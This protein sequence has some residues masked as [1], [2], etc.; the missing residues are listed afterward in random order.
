MRG[1]RGGET[2]L[3][4]ATTIVDTAFNRPKKDI[5]REPEFQERELD[6]NRESLERM[7]RTLDRDVDRALLRYRLLEVARLGASERIEPLDR[8][9]GLA[10]GMS[11]D[12]AAKAIDALLD[13]LYAGTEA[14]RQGLPFVAPQQVVR[15]SSPRWAI[16]SSTSQRRCSR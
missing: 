8:A 1:G 7:Q 3:G 5:D 14:V 13:R 15:R 11:P 6:P 4:A 16:R 12:E 10:A 2:L 9:A